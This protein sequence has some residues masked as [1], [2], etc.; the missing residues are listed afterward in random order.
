M[1]ASFQDYDH[2]RVVTLSGEFTADDADAFRRTVEDRA[3]AV[4]HLILQCEELEFIDSAGL[5]SW[6]GAQERLGEK[7]GQVRLVA[8]DATV[9]KILEL[10]RLNHA[11]ESHP[12]LEAAVR[13]LR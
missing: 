2:I 11:F 3:A 13:S 6:L 7:G 10:T 12:T 9:S 5:E 8:P 1:K 4:R